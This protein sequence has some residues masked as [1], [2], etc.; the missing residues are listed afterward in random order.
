MP[1]SER[2]LKANESKQ[3]V[4]SKK[5]KKIIII[6]VSIVLVLAIA[7]VAFLL[8]NNSQKD[9]VATVDGTKISKVD[10]LYYLKNS[11]MNVESKVILQD[12]A[13]EKRIFWESKAGIDILG[14]ALPASP[15]ETNADALK[16]LTLEDM[17]DMALEYQKA[18]AENSS[19]YSKA[20]PQVRQSILDNLKQNN[21]TQPDFTKKLLDTFGISFDKYVDIITRQQVASAYISKYTSAVA[22]TDAEVE[23]YYNSNKASLDLITVKEVFYPTVDLQT[24]AGLS[25]E[26]QAKAK[27]DADAAVVKIKNGANIDDIIKNESKDPSLSTNNGKMQV[28][29]DANSKSYYQPIS[30]ALATMKVGD[31]KSILVDNVGYYVVKYESIT[32]F[33]DVKDKA[34]QALQSSKYTVQMRTNYASIAIVENGSI[35]TDIVV[36]KI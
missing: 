1:Q 27:S 22:V 2:K 9:F 24:Q 4:K 23:T 33:S 30:D 12:T 14:D 13:D 20:S 31:V 36:N 17:R 10:Y 19:A 11:K 32:V 34:K 28:S 21:T 3:S 7:A 8:W 18:I 6:S 29:L 26:Q 16:R 15:T 5:V 25:T 35:V